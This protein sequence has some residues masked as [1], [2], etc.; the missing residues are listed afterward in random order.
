MEEIV[1]FQK[2]PSDD[3]KNQA[4]LLKKKEQEKEKINK[5]GKT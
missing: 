3:L 5:Q 1:R 2:T 4:R